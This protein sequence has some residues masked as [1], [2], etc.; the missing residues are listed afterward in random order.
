MTR[1]GWSPALSSVLKSPWPLPLYGAH[2]FGGPPAAFT[3]SDGECDVVPPAM[4]ISQGHQSKGLEALPS[5]LGHA[6]AA[7]PAPQQPSKTPEHDPPVCLGGSR[8]RAY[9]SFVVLVSKTFSAMGQHASS[10][11]FSGIFISSQPLATQFFHL[12]LKSI[13][14]CSEER[15][16]KK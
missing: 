5:H 1:R 9:A 11:V 2:D 12:N 13:C 6:P 10:A 4:R 7:P 16:K 8:A 3:N 14:S 15:K